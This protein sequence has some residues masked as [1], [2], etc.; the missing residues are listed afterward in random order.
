ML[1]SILL[2]LLQ[3]IVLFLIVKIKIDCKFATASPTQLAPF[4]SSR[5]GTQQRY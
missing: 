2:N 5:A 1:V 3:K 4:E